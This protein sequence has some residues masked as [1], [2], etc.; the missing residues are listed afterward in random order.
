MWGKLG[1]I[2]RAWRVEVGSDGKFGLFGFPSEILAQICFFFGT[3]GAFH[4]LY[5]CFLK[6][7]VL[8]I[9]N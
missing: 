6:Q 2:L 4:I 3:K 1:E 8:L 7:I 9:L 5:C